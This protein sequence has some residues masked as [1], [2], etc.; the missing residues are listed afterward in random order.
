MSIFIF[1]SFLTTR[2]EQFNPLDSILQEKLFG[3][4]CGL[5]YD[6]FVLGSFRKTPV[7]RL[8]REEFPRI[9]F[10]TEAGRPVFRIRIFILKEI[11]F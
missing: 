6:D 3:R 8:R 11:L 5:C 2:M 4:I 7:E 1:V 9:P 10:H